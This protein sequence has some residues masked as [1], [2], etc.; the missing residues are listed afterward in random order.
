MVLLGLAI[1]VPVEGCVEQLKFYC[2]KTKNGVNLRKMAKYLWPRVTEILRRPF[3][4]VLQ[5]WQYTN[6]RILLSYLM[7]CFFVGYRSLIDR[8]KKNCRCRRSALVPCEFLAFVVTT[9]SQETERKMIGF[10]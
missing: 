8:S 6:E 10:P 5:G 4:V 2:N 7:P 9:S 3:S 1:T